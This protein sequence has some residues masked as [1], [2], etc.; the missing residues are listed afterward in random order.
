MG[1]NPTAVS[2]RGDK[3][4]HQAPAHYARCGPAILRN[5]PARAPRATYEH[6][7]QTTKNRRVPLTLYSSPCLEFCSVVISWSFIGGQGALPEDLV[8]PTVRR[9]RVS[10]PGTLNMTVWPSGLR[11]W[12]QAPVRKGVG[13]SP[14]AVSLHKDETGACMFAVLR[15]LPSA[16]FTSTAAACTGSSSILVPS[17]PHP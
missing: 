6:Q 15:P 10:L 1:S 9:L 11:R 13:S 2:T 7:R 16:R 5:S 14:T 8:P 12:L 17:Q 3:K 4:G